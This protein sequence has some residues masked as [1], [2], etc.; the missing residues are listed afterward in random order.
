[1][2][3]LRLKQACESEQGG[4]CIHDKQIGTS[5]Q[6]MLELDTRIY[7]CKVHEA[8]VIYLIDI[9]KSSSISSKSSRDG[10]A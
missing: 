2:E 7:L 3:P 6:K 8:R 9:L 1:M 5:F 4:H 10:L